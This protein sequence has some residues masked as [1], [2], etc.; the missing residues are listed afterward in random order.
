MDTSLPPIHRVD[1]QSHPDG[2]KQISK[3]DE[4]K[5]ANFALTIMP[6]KCKFKLPCGRCEVTKELCDYE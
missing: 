4:I 1:M 5:N 3:T 6:P 2:Y